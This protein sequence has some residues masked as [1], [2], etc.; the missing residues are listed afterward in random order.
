VPKRR[1]RQTPE[2]CGAPP[3]ETAHIA[4]GGAPNR[5]GEIVANA[6]VGPIRPEDGEIALYVDDP[7][8]PVKIVAYMQ[9]GSTP[10]ER[11]NEAIAAGLWLEG[12]YAPS[13]ENAVRLHRNLETGPWLWGA[14]E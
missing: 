14:L 4:T 2:S 8:D 7:T 11:T 6:P 9:W 12:F 3:E 5:V 1:L 13:G 10:H